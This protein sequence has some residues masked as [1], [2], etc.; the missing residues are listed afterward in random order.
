MYARRRIES[1]AGL[2]A[3]TALLSLGCS[4]SPVESPPEVTEWQD[5]ARLPSG[6]ADFGIAVF[7]DR[8]YVVGGW[9]DDLVATRSVYRY[10]PDAD[11]WDRLSDFPVEIAD[12]DL[13]VSRD[14]LIALGGVGATISHP[15]RM[16]R[17]YDPGSDTWTR[18]PSIPDERSGHAAVEVDGSIYLLGGPVK[19]EADEHGPR[20]PGD[21]VLVYDVLTASWAY[22]DPMHRPMYGISGVYDGGLIHTF[23]GVSALNF[24]PNDSVRSYDPVTDDWLATGYDPNSA[25]GPTLALLNGEVH[26][27]GARANRAAHQSYNLAE[28]SWSFHQRIWAPLIGTGAVVY[29][30][31]LYVLGGLFEGQAV[32]RAQVYRPGG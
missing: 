2:S 15:S 22:R 12:V 18:R 14:T 23:G 32:T 20:I 25:S 11:A 9:A 17:V 13:I 6:R 4:D 3:I 16:V 30:G 26:V 8:I 28:R 27:I 24:L 5:I 10:D 1:I 29:R 7:R 21:S 19:L 31:E